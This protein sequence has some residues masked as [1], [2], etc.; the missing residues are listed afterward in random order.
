MKKRLG[1]S[2]EAIFEETGL[3]LSALDPEGRILVFNSAMEELTGLTSAE[4]LGRSFSEF[5]VTD[6]TKEAV[7]AYLDSYGEGELPDAVELPITT[8]NGKKRIISWK[9]AVVSAG[10]SRRDIIVAVGMDI[11]ERRLAEEALASSEGFFRMLIENALDLVT[12][13]SADG[14]IVYTGPSVERLLGY[15]QGEIVGRDLMGFIHPDERQAARAALD[16]AIGHPG[17]SGNIKLRIRHMDGGW[18]VHE[19]SSFNLL[20]DPAVQGMVINSRDIT[21][22]KEAEDKLSLRSR[23]IEAI[24]QALPDLYFRFSLDGTIL[25]YGAGRSAYLYAKPEDFLGKKVFDMLPPGVGDIA[26]NLIRDVGENREPRSFEYTLP[27]P[28]ALKRYEARMLPA[29][30][31]QVIAVVRDITEHDELVSSLRES[32]E[33]YR[34]TFEST[35]SAMVILGIDG[36]I[37]DANQEIGKLLGYS[38]EE[39]VGKRKY[40]EF[41]HPEDRGFIKR[42]SLRLL[43]G[44][45]KGP[46]RYEARTVR[47]D[48]RILNTI[49]VVSTLPGMDSSVASIM[50]ITEKKTYELE[51]E[52]RAAQ[53]RDFLD[54]A[55]HELRHPATLIEGYADTLQRYGMGMTREDLATSLAGIV[56]GANKLTGVVE[57]LLDV[58]RIE[59]GFMSLERSGHALEPLVRGAVEEMSARIGDRSIE[60]SSVED[61]GEAWLDPEKFVRLMIILLDN[62]AKYSP[63]ESPVEVHLG[64]GGREA[65]VSV[66]DRGVGIPEGERDRVFDRFYQ[67]GGVLHHSTPG[68][69]LGL[70]IAR[71]IVEAH[72]GRIWCEAREEGGTVFR[73][74]MPLRDGGGTA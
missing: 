22:R 15:R 48:G 5:S 40:L 18:R 51:L 36:T 58:S 3:L 2:F 43:K 69:G 50:D 56:K 21:E 31:D 32:E 30:E 64:Q 4:V 23:E 1:I 16:Y 12:V 11:T 37:L 39:V 57:D 53:L 46:V 41:V 26:A 9:A 33:K 62:A 44:E 63:P 20:D 72:G 7:G 42:Y 27:S 8:K 6:S 54:I 47:R 52:A 34:V 24:F 25:D 55:A 10:K 38:R 68:L 28:Q 71:R 74:T 59:R 65:L 70:Y 29:L 45:L 73:F 14:R 60:I 13:L 17:I 19:A 66:F 49:I 67:S 35:G 61:P